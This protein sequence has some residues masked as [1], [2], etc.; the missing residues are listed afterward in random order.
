[1]GQE[2]RS[3]RFGLEA[4]NSTQSVGQSE[5][6]SVRLLG[7]LKIA[8]RIKVKVKRYNN[9]LSTRPRFLAKESGKIAEE[10]ESESLRQLSIFVRP[11]F[12]AEQN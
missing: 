6:Q 1:M 5:V 8:E 11:D 12:L 4:L 2:G 9:S 7:Q 10:S 3:G